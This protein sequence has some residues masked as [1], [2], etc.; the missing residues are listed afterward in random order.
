MQGSLLCFPLSPIS[1][2]QH[3]STLHTGT[4]LPKQGRSLWLRGL[5]ISR[6][7]FFG[8]ELF[9]STNLGECQMNWGERY[10]R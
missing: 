9:K 7:Y 2:T 8:G 1:T 3:A 10:Q 5:L 4:Q 6:L